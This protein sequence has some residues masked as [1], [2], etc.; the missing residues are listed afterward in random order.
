MALRVLS[1]IYRLYALILDFLTNI[2]FESTGG[3]SLE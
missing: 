3:N 2:E 1:I